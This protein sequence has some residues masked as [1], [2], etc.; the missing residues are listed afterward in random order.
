MLPIL[1]WDRRGWIDKWIDLRVSPCF[2]SYV[3]VVALLSFS[4]VDTLLGFFVDLRMVQSLPNFPALLSFRFLSH[5]HTRTRTRASRS[6]HFGGG[7]RL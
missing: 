5:K 3:L 6:S 7:V 4:R 2:L 1:R